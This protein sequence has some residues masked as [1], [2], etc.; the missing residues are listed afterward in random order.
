MIE[1]ND[2]RLTNQESYL[3]NKLLIA[4]N[5]KDR[6]TNTDHDH[7]EFCLERF[8]EDISDLNFGYSTED[9]YY[10]ICDECYNDFKNKLGWKLVIQ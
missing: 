7:C 8:S 5:Y 1:E 10:W 9:N 4:K 2:W 6:I 3:K